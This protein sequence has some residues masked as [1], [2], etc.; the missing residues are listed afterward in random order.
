MTKEIKKKVTPPKKSPKQ[1]DK[2]WLSRLEDYISQHERVFLFVTLALTLL[3]SFLMFDV[4]MSEGN[5]DSDYIEGAFK[6][7]RDASSYYN[8]KAPLYPMLLSV[9]VTIWGINVPLLKSLS[10]LFNLLQLFVLYLAFRKTVPFTILFGVLLFTATN[11]YFQYYASQTYT[12]AFFCMLQAMFFLFIVRT[13]NTAYKGFDK[14]YFWAGAILFLLT[15]TKNISIGAILAVLLFFVVIKEYKKLLFILGSF[16][17]LRVPFEIL[18]SSIWGSENQFSN[19]YQILIQ[20][21]A[22]DA[23]KGA[24]D[25]FGFLG[26]LADNTSIYIGKRYYQILGLVSEDKTTFNNGLVFIFIVLMIIALI[27]ILKQK[28]RILLFALFYVVIMM[29]MTFFVLQTNWDQPRMILVYVPLTLLIIFY[30]LYHIFG[31]Q[32]VARNIIFSLFFI[33]FTFGGLFKTLGKAGNNVHVLEKNL[34]GDIYYGYTEDW[35]NF[36]KLSRYCADSLPPNSL[37]ASRKAPMSFIYGR[38]KEFYPIYTVISSD[39]DSSLAILKKEKVTHVLIASLRRNP[40]K[41]DGFVI[42]T[43]HRIFMPIAQKYPKKLV[44]IKQIGNSEP[45]YLYEIKY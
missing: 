17:V 25:F 37:V 32:R 36:L 41:N 9:P 13:I 14:N 45:A 44:L 20:K 16:A 34:A 1:E 24:D 40:K 43:L 19:Q 3:L 11:S 22:Y 8:T 21:D 23:S 38:G 4:K 18:K 26:R 5:D 12:E 31:K 27:A 10:I 42:N 29:G 35:S 7:S 33:L 15:L 2:D 6:F 28:N 30:G 39:P